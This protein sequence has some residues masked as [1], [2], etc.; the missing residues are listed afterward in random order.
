MSAPHAPPRTATVTL[1]PA[2]LH[3][4]AARLADLDV[5]APASVNLA[6]SSPSENDPGRVHRAEALYDRGATARS[7]AAWALVQS[8][9]PEHRPVARWVA[10]GA[11]VSANVDSW[12]GLLA[13][14]LGP[15]ELA[16]HV[17]LAAAHVARTR[18]EV[19]VARAMMRQGM[20]V[21]RAVAL[22]RANAAHNGALEAYGAAVMQLDA[23]GRVRLAAL[24]VAVEG[25][26]ARGDGRD[27]TQA[28]NATTRAQNAD[29]A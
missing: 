13:R 8:L 29:A 12:P 3:R 16:A 20:T 1:D 28:E 26:G 5:A 27:D 19:T 6:P 14:A 10:S 15:R 7:R 2:A 23:W 11:P 17:D 4:L 21:P 22:E 24:L 9:A 18:G 25:V